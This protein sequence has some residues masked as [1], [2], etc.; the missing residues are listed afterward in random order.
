MKTE[1]DG[2]T[3]SA[4]CVSSSIIITDPN[5]WQ[6]NSDIFRNCKKQNDCCI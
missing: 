3:T 5:D 2:I 4:N 6:K 1:K